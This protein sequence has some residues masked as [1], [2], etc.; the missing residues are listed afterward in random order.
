M[1]ALKRLNS[2]KPCGR[3]SCQCFEEIRK[4]IL[5]I[6][7]SDDEDDKNERELQ[8]YEEYHKK[9]LSSWEYFKNKLN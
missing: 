3:A 5:H 9:C 2:V 8:M 7:I 1:Y 4:C 6:P